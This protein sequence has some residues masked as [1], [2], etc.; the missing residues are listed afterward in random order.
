MEVSEPSLARTILGFDVGLSGAI[1][2]VQEGCRVG[3]P[4][5]LV[6][7]WSYPMA[8]KGIDWAELH[9]ML[10]TWRYHSIAVVEWAQAMP[11]NGSV[12]MFNYGVTF[13][14]VIA[15][16]AA[17]RIR[18]ELVRPQAWKKLIIPGAYG[19]E[20]FE[21]KA[22]AVAYCRRAFPDTSLT[23]PG[24]RVPND[25]MADALCIAE[26]GRRLFHHVTEST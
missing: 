2:R 14:G 22:A 3:D 1:A 19:K 8:G 17:L 13:G 26:Y 9:R 7:V 15:I 16:L 10:A 24:C 25:G 6:G 18:V 5:T 4:P 11:G 23:P 12:S 21:Q 20:K